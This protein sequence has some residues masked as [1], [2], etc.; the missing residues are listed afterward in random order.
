MTGVVNVLLHLASALM[1]FTWIRKNLQGSYSMSL[2][3]S[4]TKSYREPYF[5]V[6]NIISYYIHLYVGSSFKTIFSSSHGHNV[7]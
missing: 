1:K 2:E 6:T 4:L 3:L 5:Y 7:E